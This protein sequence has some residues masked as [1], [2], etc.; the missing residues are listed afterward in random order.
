MTQLKIG[1]VVKLK[2]G[3]P[4]MTVYSEGEDG[5]LVCQWFEG[6][7]VKSASFP[8]ASLQAAE[9]PPKPVAPP[10]VTFAPAI[11]RLDAQASD[12]SEGGGYAR[13]ACRARGR[14]IV[15]PSRGAWSDACVF[16]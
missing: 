14:R 15:G 5:H 3:G 1:D 10:A 12:V 13:G 9:A 6:S 11:P 7:D 2:S 8:T 16:G 4:M